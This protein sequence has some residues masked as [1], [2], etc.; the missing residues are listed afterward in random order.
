MLLSFLVIKSYKDY[1]AYKVADI[2]ERNKLKSE[3]DIA[4]N[5]NAAKGLDIF[6]ELN[7][8]YLIEERLANFD[9]KNPKICVLKYFY[10]YLTF[11]L[12]YPSL[13]GGDS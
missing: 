1:R 7:S 9:G 3:D 8:P 2:L 11:N 12:N 6:E 4:G 5:P 10:I 13:K